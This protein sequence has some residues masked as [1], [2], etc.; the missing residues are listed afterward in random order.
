MEEILAQP[1]TDP[2]GGEVNGTEAGEIRANFDDVWDYHNL[3]NT[4]GATDQSGT[5]VT[6]LEN[7]NVSVVVSSVTIGTGAGSPALR[8]RILVSHDGQ[9]GINVPITAY[10]LN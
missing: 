3:N 2:D 9:V 6:G 5:A 1:L 7:Y 4:S 10:R 8:I